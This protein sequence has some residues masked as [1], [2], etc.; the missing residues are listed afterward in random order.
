MY[1]VDLIGEPGLS[2]PA[3]PPLASGAYPLWFGDVLDGLGVAR[4]SVVGVSLGGWL[5]LDYSSRHPERVERLVLLTPAGV[6]KQKVAGL[7][8]AMLLK[9]FGEWG[10]R[11]SMELFLGP[12]IRTQAGSMAFVRLLSRHFRYRREA[13]PVVGDAG[14]GR[15][16]MP[17]LAVLGARDTFIDSPRTAERLSRLAPSAT[18]R[19]LPG[20]G[21]LLPAQTAPILEFLTAG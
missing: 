2:A 12:E 13:V 14:L 16:T 5:A 10:E 1:A 9:P 4:A 6:A 3:R 17:I 21:H 20:V 18:V 11:R 8:G 15:A 19:V 7:I